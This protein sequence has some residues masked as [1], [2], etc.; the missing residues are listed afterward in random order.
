MIQLGEAA[1]VA[2]WEAARDQ[3]P[4]DRALT[5]LA[6]AWPARSRSE[7]SQ[8]PIGERDR[9][10]FALRE[11]MF[12]ARLALCARCPSCRD[13]CEL[14]IALRDLVHPPVD[15]TEFAID[16]DGKPLRCR[17]PDSRDLACAL[18][19]GDAASAR[20]ALAQRCV[21]EGPSAL[22]DGMIDALAA[23]IE[24][25]DPQ[26]EVRFA[27]CCPMCDHGWKA[28]LDVGELLYAEL[29]ASARALVGEV[30]ALAWAY[31]W[32]EADILAM[33]AA[34]RRLYLQMVGYD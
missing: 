11:R 2:V 6:S 30:H 22:D 24:A 16:V 33:T 13:T 18:A 7:L 29:A 25:C 32:S 12:G 1:I 21:I 10:L 28:E 5:L 3:H 19:I 4:V 20:R 15:R 9:L 27:L 23:A 14:E 8:L 17:L 31:K 26:I 34:R